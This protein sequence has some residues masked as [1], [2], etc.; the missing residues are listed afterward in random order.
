MAHKQDSSPLLFAH[1]LHLPEA[2]FLKLDVPHGEHFVGDQD[3][4]VEVRCDGEGEPHVHAAGVAL[5]GG[6]D[7]F[8]LDFGERDDLVEVSVDVGLG[9]AEDRA[10]EVDVF[11]P[12][13][14]RMKAC[15][16]F[17]QARHVAAHLYNSFCGSRYLGKDLEERRFA[18]AVAADDAQALALLDFEVDVLE[19]PEPFSLA[20]AR[21]LVYFGPRVGLALEFCGPALDVLPEASVAYDAEAVLFGKVLYFDCGAHGFPHTTSIKVCSLWLKVMRPKRNTTTET[22]RLY[23]HIFRLQLPFPKKEYRNISMT[24]ATGLN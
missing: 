1:L 6:V 3:F 19:R 4:G 11:P 8:R 17:K 14:F 23:A 13:E 5:D 7:E 2:F 21:F 15:P 16:H 18:C 9:H 24:G 10:V 22:M 12:R 20:D